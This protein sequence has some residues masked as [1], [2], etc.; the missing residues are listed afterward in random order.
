MSTCVEKDCRR[1]VWEKSKHCIDH[2]PN[3]L[4]GPSLAVQ[5]QKA[6]DELTDLEAELR[7]TRA[8]V[9]SERMEKKTS[10]FTR[11][12]QVA[13]ALLDAH[14]VERALTGAAVGGTDGRPSVRRRNDYP[15]PGSATAGARRAA[16][17]LRESLDDAVQSFEAAKH[18]EWRRAISDDPIPKLRCGIRGCS[19]KDLEVPAWRYVRGGRKIYKTHCEACGTLLPGVEKNEETA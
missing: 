3:G 4:S 15:Q 14:E 7:A 17:K 10:D 5:L 16:K 1:P 13:R 6:R 18:R 2:H 12:E 9:V 19:A 11:L 8:V